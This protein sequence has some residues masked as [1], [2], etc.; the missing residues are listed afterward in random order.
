MKVTKLSLFL[1]GALSVLCTC[2]AAQIAYEGFDYPIGSTLSNQTGGTGWM[3]PWLGA[4]LGGGGANPA[5]V[6]FVITNGLNWS[7]SNGGYIVG[8][9]GAIFVHDRST[10]Y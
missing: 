3:A 1:I 7:N 6:D 4:N 2:Q 10:A 5:E 9:G 8:N